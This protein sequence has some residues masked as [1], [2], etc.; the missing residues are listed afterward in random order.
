[1][2]SNIPQDKGSKHPDAN[3]ENI[4]LY[5][6]IIKSGITKVAT[7]LEIFLCAEVISW[8]LPQEGEGT[9]IMSNIEGKYFSSFTPAY[10]AKACNLL[11]PKIS[12]TDD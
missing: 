6:D 5:T 2:G 11:A 8:M 1:M 12:M 9:M 7:R 4:P 10:I 3:L